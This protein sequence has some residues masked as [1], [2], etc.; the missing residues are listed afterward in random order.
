MVP[1]IFLFSGIGIK[2]RT[3]ELR[4]KTSWHGFTWEHLSVWWFTG[5]YF[6]VS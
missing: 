3:C 5:A 6:M 1:V 2:E 4:A